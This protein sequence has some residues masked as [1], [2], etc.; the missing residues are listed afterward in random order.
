MWFVYKAL[1][2]ALKI[3]DHFLADVIRGYNRTVYFQLNNHCD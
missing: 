2:K 1:I 3:N